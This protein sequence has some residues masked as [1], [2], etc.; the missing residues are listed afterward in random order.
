LRVPTIN[1][2]SAPRAAL[3]GSGNQASDIIKTASI[4]NPNQLT[5]AG[6]IAW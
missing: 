3:D 1:I 4:E 5:R 6:I 2:S